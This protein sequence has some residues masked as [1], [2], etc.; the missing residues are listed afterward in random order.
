MPWSLPVVSL[1]NKVKTLLAGGPAANS[2]AAGWEMGFSFNANSLPLD[3]KNGSHLL[4]SVLWK[5]QLV[6]AGP[7]VLCSYIPKK[8]IMQN[9]KSFLVSPNIL[10]K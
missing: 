8:M 4:A 7:A 10:E 5:L 1:P 3:V 2:V 9:S 6:P